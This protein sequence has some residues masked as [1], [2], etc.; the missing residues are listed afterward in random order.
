MR[1]LFVLLG[2]FG[3]LW[4]GM[5]DVQAQSIDQTMPGI[6]HFHR[7]KSAVVRLRPIFR[8]KSRETIRESPGGFGT[9]FLVSRQ[10][11]IVTADHNL[12]SSAEKRVPGP[13]YELHRVEVSFE[14]GDK[15]VRL[16]GGI[17][18]Q[19]PNRAALV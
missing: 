12:N 15:C 19:N 4:A 5:E 13:D 7:G 9:G 10:G 2:C 8:L 17:C 3:L 1:Q 6:Q 11:H 14:D 18:A 16:Q